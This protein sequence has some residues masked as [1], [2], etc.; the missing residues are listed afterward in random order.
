MDYKIIDELYNIYLDEFIEVAEDEFELYFKK[1]QMNGNHDLEKTLQSYISDQI[2]FF[3]NSFVS[4]KDDKNKVDRIVRETASAF[5]AM[6]P[7]VQFFLNDFLYKDEN[8][9]ELKFDGTKIDFVKP[10]DLFN[11]DIKF[12]E[13]ALKEHDDCFE[14]AFE[15]VLNIIKYVK[16]NK[17]LDKLYADGSWHEINFE[18]LIANLYDKA[19]NKKIFEVDFYGIT[20]KED[21][22]FD[23]LKENCSRVSTIEFDKYRPQLASSKQMRAE[24]GKLIFCKNLLEFY[25]TGIMPDNDGLIDW[26]AGEY[27]SMEMID[28][29]KEL[30]SKR[31]DEASFRARQSNIICKPEILTT[32]YDI[33]VAKKVNIGNRMVMGY[34]IDATYPFAPNND[35]IKYLIHINIEDV[36]NPCS[37]YEMQLNIL[38]KGKISNRLQL[39]RLDNWDS[40][41]PHKNIA[42][43]LTTTTH[44]HLYNEFDLIRGRVNGNYDIA[45]NLDAKS[46]DF[47]TSLKTFLKILEFD[48]L[49]QKRIFNTTMKC[50]NNSKITEKTVES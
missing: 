25:E 11:M 24:F 1:Y 38:P 23:K 43:K 40:E 18:E 30:Y 47:E 5:E 34:I 8:L 10:H 29:F 27:D 44:I 31:F 16:Q 37:N 6:V 15:Q 41:Q 17:L 35:S 39:M 33:Q 26:Y 9:E 28:E 49:T 3:S 46:T 19:K 42:K 45:Y 2:K 12:I 7:P 13:D 14:E 50:V 22:L 20:A 36:Y 32:D 4:N 48:P 21:S